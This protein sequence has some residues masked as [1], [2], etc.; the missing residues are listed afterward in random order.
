[1][2]LSFY[3]D[4]IFSFSSIIYLLLT[5]P[6]ILLPKSENVVLPFF[7]FLFLIDDPILPIL[8]LKNP[9]N[10]LPLLHSLSLSS[11]AQ[12]FSPR[13]PTSSSNWLLSHSQPVHTVTRLIFLKC[14]FAFLLKII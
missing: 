11:D 8:Y 6:Y 7:H 12:H 3:L 1:M 4:P 14:K 2:F 5:I 9:S 13:S 10:I